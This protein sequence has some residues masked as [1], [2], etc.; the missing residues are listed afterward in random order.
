MYSA[1]YGLIK[2][3]YSRTRSPALA[4]VPLAVRPLPEVAGL[5]RWLVRYVVPRLTAS[6]VARSAKTKICRSPVD[7]QMMGSQFNRPP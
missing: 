1:R 7:A 4:Q 3:A 2:P 5:V 6:S